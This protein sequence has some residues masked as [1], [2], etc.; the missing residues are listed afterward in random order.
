MN[1][2]EIIRIEIKNEALKENFY[3]FHSDYIEVSE[4]ILL[5]YNK[6]REKR[7]NR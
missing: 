6:D 3:V 4:Y 5:R 7:R 2:N 1:R